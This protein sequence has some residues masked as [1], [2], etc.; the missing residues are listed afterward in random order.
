AGNAG[1]AAFAQLISDE[2][3]NSGLT[4]MLPGVTWT[5]IL[6]DGAN[7]GNIAAADSPIAGPEDV[8]AYNTQAD[9][10]SNN[11]I[12]SGTLMNAVKYDSSGAAVAADADALNGLVSVWTRLNIPGDPTHF[13]YGDATSSAAS[14]FNFTE[15]IDGTQ[16]HHLYAISSVL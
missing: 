7:G 9:Q 10:L 13:Q 15:V 14:W 4:A 12:Y 8:P 11:S 6:T 1:A 3:T 2:A 16:Q 5:A